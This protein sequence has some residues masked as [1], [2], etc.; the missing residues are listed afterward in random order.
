MVANG[1]AEA[2]AQASG[3]SETDQKRL[4]VGGTDLQTPK[5]HGVGHKALL[6]SQHPQ[7]QGWSS[8][9]AVPSTPCSVIIYYKHHRRTLGS[10]LQVK[11]LTRFRDRHL[12]LCNNQTLFNKR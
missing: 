6:C 4:G 1:K 7:S 11:M 12:S 10:Q 5:K 2:V 3:A 9:R 8:V